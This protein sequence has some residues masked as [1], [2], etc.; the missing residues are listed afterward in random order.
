MI[1]KFAQALDLIRE[2]HEEHGLNCSR[3]SIVMTR[4]AFDRIVQP[5]VLG[6]YFTHMQHGSGIVVWPKGDRV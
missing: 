5:P 6:I 1:D 3:V 2:A 4:E